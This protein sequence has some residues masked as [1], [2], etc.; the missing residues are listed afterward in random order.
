MFTDRLV[1]AAA[2][3]LDRR[4]DRRGFLAR[5]AVV[6][7]AVSVSGFEY[8]LR[9]QTAYASVCGDGASCSSGWTA[10][11]CTINHGVNQCPPGSFAGGWWK[12][13]GASLCG[14]K[15]RY[16]VDC[17]AECTGC[18]CHGGAFCSEHCWNCR[19]HCAHGDRC[20][21]RR[22]CHNVFRYGQCRRDKHCSGPVLC[23]AISCT[24]PWEWLDCSHASASEQVTVH[25][26]AACLPRWS[27]LQ[28]RYRSMG[29]QGSVLG[30][31]VYAERRVG[32]A[33]IQ[34]F[35][36]GRMYWSSHTGAHWLTG[37][38]LNRYLHLGETSSPLR[39]PTS[40][41]VTVATDGS[42]HARFQHGVIYQEHGYDAFGLWGPI[43]T[44]WTTLGAERG[45]LG[46]PRSD[47]V[48]DDKGGHVARFAGG[49]IY[50]DPADVAHPRAVWGDVDTKY[51]AVGGVDG[52]LGYPTGS[53]T[54]I[55]VNGTA[56]T[57]SS[58]VNGVIEA[59]ATSPPYAV[60]GPIYQT[61]V[62]SYGGPGGQLGLPT[63]DVTEIPDGEECTFQHG[64][65][66][67]NA[68]T[69]QVTV[70]AD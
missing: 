3:F 41:V 43:L 51:R 29:S 4:L 64:S 53:P 12:A 26:S 23:R 14:G 52:P 55:D 49:S 68:T 67:Y 10:M 46:F 18:G 38:V 1:R 60:W 48:A 56:V 17:Q 11:C 59:T 27:P 37:A 19:P 34:R 65:A 7:S 28:Q 61:W 63:S 8:I 9:P 16:Y 6:G 22:V 40:D 69:G 13:H 45:V 33:R 36:H 24:P 54:G 57:Q 15:A 21:K 39:L 66:T 32:G 30:A 42:R 47:V 70:V 44:V 2:G 50:Q 5:A 62:T 20:D 25:H 35:L 31:T 58:F